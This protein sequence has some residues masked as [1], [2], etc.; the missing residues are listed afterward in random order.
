MK[1]Q[2]L[3]SICILAF[4]FAAQNVYAAPADDYKF[5]GSVAAV[6]EMCLG[7]TKISERINVV[8]PAAV[9]KNPEITEIMNSL[10]ESYNSAYMKAAADA[11][12][13]EATQQGTFKFSAP[14]NC[15]DTKHVEKIKFMHDY[16]LKNLN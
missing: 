7:S 12:I 6:S 11:R 3:F 4:V 13:W 10:I 9:K 5:F 2:S 1:K 16:I 8:V 15:R 14:M